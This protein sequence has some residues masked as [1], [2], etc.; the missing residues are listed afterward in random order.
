MNFVQWEKKLNL[1]SYYDLPPEQH[2]IWKWLCKCFLK[3]NLSHIWRVSRPNAS[4]TQVCLYDCIQL[5]L[6]FSLRMYPT[7]RAHQMCQALALATNVRSTITV[8][9]NHSLKDKLELPIHPIPRVFSPWKHN[10]WIQLKYITYLLLPLG[11][12]KV[13]GEAC[14]GLD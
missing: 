10:P 8:P 12:R 11:N 14:T 9:L 2:R 1:H 5:S 4:D 13:G 3:H 7:L 6:G